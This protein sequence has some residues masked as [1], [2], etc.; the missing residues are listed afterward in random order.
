MDD[1]E[2][3]NDGQI[4]FE[5]FEKKIRTWKFSSYCQTDWSYSSHSRTNVLLSNAII[6]TH[7]SGVI[8]AHVPGVIYARPAYRY[9][10]YCE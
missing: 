10:D 8:A 1:I 7:D 3:S 5:E 2:T 9:T 4:T 6:A